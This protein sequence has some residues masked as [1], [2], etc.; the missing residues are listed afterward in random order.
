MAFDAHA[1]FA[2]STVATAPS[3]ATTGTSLVVTGGQGSRFPAVPFNA[4]VCPNALPTPANAEVVRVTARSADTLTITRTQEGSSARPIVAGDMIF[5][6]ITA[7]TLTDLETGFQ[8]SDATLTAL[9]GLDAATGIVVETAA[10][11]FTKRTLTGTA[12]RVTVTNAGGA[13]GNP[14]LDVGSD[15]YV[16][17]GTDVAIADGGTGASTAAAARTNLDAAQSSVVDA[18]YRQV[19]RFALS[20][21][22]ANIT[23]AGDYLAPTNG[24]VVAATAAGTN[25]FPIELYAADYAISGRTTKLRLVADLGFNDNAPTVTFKVG[26]YPVGNPSGGTTVWNPNVSAVIAASQIT[27]TT[28]GANV[29]AGSQNSGDFTFPSDGRYIFGVNASGAMAANSYGTM[30]LRL[31]VRNV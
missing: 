17:G 29:W 14:T 13:G 5:A 22:T 28:P 2:I 25:W 4:V 23:G 16:A 15:V 8:A 24:A 10:D 6:A 1:N 30:P 7:K 19:L 11:T 9:A 26:L 27:F 21:K 18:R 31:E 20:L 12:N 3:P